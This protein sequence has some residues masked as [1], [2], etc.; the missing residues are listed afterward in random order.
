MLRCAPTKSLLA[1]VT[2]S[3]GDLEI[4][5]EELNDYSLFA[6][7]IVSPA[8]VGSPRYTCAV[9]ILSRLVAVGYILKG[10]RIRRV[11]YYGIPHWHL[12]YNRCV[13]KRANK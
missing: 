9:V 3:I 6:M 1:H 11:H 5:R 10:R 7:K 12:L 2:T 8:S 13:Q 4:S